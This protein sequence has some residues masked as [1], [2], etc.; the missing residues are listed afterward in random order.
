MQISLSSVLAKNGNILTHTHDLGAELYSGRD[1]V[2]EL[3]SCVGSSGVLWKTA[4]SA[5]QIPVHKPVQTPVFLAFFCRD[6]AL[7]AAGT[8]CWAGYGPVVFQPCSILAQLRVAPQGCAFCWVFSCSVLKITRHL[9]TFRI[10]FSTLKHHNSL[11]KETLGRVLTWS[12]L[13]RK[14]SSFLLFFQHDFHWHDQAGK[15]LTG[16]Q[17]RTAMQYL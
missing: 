3:R 15:R 17:P 2:S 7:A 12:M 4:Q 13:C 16:W 8:G 6:Q 14:E 9:L 1:S 11:F 10:H 5:G